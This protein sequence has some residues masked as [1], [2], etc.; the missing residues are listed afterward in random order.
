MQDTLNPRMDVG[1]FDHLLKLAGPTG[2]N[3]L[4]AQLE[5]DLGR[6]AAALAEA[7]AADDRAAVRAATHVL[8]SVA[9]SVGADGLSADARVLNEVAH[10]TEPLPAAL[11]ATIADGIA[12][13]RALVCRHRAMRP[14]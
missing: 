8:I 12:A 6:N 1:R 13:L 2:G 14:G 10:G 5:H 4:L 3:V 9:G 7:V 11:A